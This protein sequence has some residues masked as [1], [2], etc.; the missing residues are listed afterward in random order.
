MF[1]YPLRASAS[2]H[3]FALQALLSYLLEQPVCLNSSKA[4]LLEVEGKSLKTSFSSLIFVCAS[5][6]GV[7]HLFWKPILLLPL[8]SCISILFLSLTQKNKINLKKIKKGKKKDRKRFWQGQ[9]EVC[10]WQLA[11]L[12]VGSVCHVLQGYGYGACWYSPSFTS[13]D[14]GVIWNFYRMWCIYCALM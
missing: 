12:A 11:V 10:K 2:D 5:C 14:S 4:S 7:Q 9:P 1:A 13:S 3:W 8:I 6:L